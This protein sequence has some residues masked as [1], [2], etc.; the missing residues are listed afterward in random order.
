MIHY[1]R[2]HANSEFKTF[3]ES[4]SNLNFHQLIITTHQAE[5][6]IEI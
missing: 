6:Q 2:K 3:A 4:D 1:Q 5:E